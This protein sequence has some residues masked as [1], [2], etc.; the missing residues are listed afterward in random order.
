MSAA[1][2]DSTDKKADACAK[3]GEA[4]P[5]AG[6]IVW[7][8]PIRFKADGTSQFRRGTRVRAH[9][10]QACGHITLSLESR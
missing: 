5:V 1:S 2:T 9:A 7:T 10:C 3:C 4:N 8:G 6:H